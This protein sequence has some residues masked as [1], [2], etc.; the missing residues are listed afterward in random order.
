[1]SSS[2]SIEWT[3]GILYR[4]TL[5]KAHPEAS[6][7]GFRNGVQE[8]YFKNQEE[9]DAYTGELWIDGLSDVTIEEVINETA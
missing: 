5:N 9:I 7:H 6:L 3:P 2:Q 1:M 4:V 8:R